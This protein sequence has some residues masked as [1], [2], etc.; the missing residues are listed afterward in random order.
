MNSDKLFLLAAD[1]LL[2]VHLAFVAFVVIG[3]LLIVLG[4]IRKWNWVRNRWFR[5]LH[6][7]SILIVVL[8]SWF[9]LM[10][11]LTSWET[12]LREHAGDSTYSGD[13]IAHWVEKI[14]FYQFSPWVFGVCY[15]VFGFVVLFAWFYVRPNRYYK[16]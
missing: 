13:F 15:T 12:S 2:I 11:P 6:L 14:L 8:Q 3:L 16:N 4:G 5:V 10:C 9:G 7:L 1:A